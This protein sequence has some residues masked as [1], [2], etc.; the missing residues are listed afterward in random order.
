MLLFCTIGGVGHI[1]DNPNNP[2]NLDN[3]RVWF[4]STQGNVFGVWLVED[5]SRWGARID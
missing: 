5:I 1:L 3:S 4:E 2:D